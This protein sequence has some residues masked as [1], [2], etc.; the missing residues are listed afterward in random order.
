LLL[1]GEKEEVNAGCAGAVKCERALRFLLLLVVRCR[2]VA[3]VLSTCS[4]NP[5]EEKG[6]GGRKYNNNVARSSTK[7]LLLAYDLV[8]VSAPSLGRCSNTE[9]DYKKQSILYMHA[10]TH[11]GSQARTQ[12]QLSAKQVVT[13]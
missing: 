3:V 13:Y 1:E 4:S 10:R 5:N 12:A 11:A 9:R 7:L 2:S 6:G 8:V